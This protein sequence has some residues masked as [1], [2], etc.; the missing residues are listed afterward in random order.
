[1]FIRNSTQQKGVIRD[2]VQYEHYFWSNTISGATL[3]WDVAKGHLSSKGYRSRD[4]Q[5]TTLYKII[6]QY[7]ER[8]ELEWE[9]RYQERYGYLRLS[10]HGLIPEIPCQQYFYRGIYERGCARAKCPDW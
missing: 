9:A 6:D 7:H 4:S 3:R 10:S 2:G 5:G 1:L 8:F